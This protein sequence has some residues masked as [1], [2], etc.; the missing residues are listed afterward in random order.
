MKRQH[1]ASIAIISAPI[2]AV[3]IALAADKYMVR[4][5]SGISFS[6]VRG[7]ERWQMISVSQSDAGIGCSTSPD[8]GCIKSILG[9]PVMIKAYADGFPG[10]G[11]PVPDGAMF[12]K[13]EWAS[14]RNTEAGYEMTLPGN[15]AEVGV[16]V[17]N[18]KRFRQR[19]GWGYAKFQYNNAS[20]TWTAFGD[21]PEFQNA[22]HACHTLVKARDFV[23]THYPKR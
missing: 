23:W 19:N 13:I 3:G 4:S 2:L 22:W 14:E 20:D 16:M 11:K 6:E 17:K 7:Y 10:N 18:S 12:V 5:P 21:S 9:N 8:P 15:L 1:I